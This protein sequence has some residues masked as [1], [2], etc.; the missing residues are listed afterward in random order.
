MNAKQ[1]EGKFAL[2]GARFKVSVVP[3]QRVSKDYAM[4]IQW[5]R[6]EPLRRGAGQAHIVEQ[7]YRVAGE[8]VY[9]CSK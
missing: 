6:N 8:L 5:N 3:S 4:D 1:I 2:L 7:L 9:V